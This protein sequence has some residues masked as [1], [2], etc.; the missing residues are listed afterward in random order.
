MVVVVVLL[1]GLFRLGEAEV[2]GVGVG[3]AVR[4][5]V[6]GLLA[7]GVGFGGGYMGSARSRRFPLPVRLGRDLE[8]GSSYSVGRGRR[9]GIAVSSPQEP[10]SS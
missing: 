2:V 7:V 10:L 5:G 4:E 8:V 9:E 1:F 6:V 3:K